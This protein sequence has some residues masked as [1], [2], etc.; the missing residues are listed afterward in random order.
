MKKVIY[1]AVFAMVSLS[2]CKKDECKE[3]HYD[4]PNGEVELGEKCGDD[5]ED[6]EASGHTVDGQTYTVHC[7]EGH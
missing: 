5:I 4:G 2:S 7:G 1:L 6:L 3:C